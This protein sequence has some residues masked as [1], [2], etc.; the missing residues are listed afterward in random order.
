VPDHLSTFAATQR[1]NKKAT[2]NRNRNLAAYPG[3]ASDLTV[4]LL[5]RAPH[6]A[7]VEET[8]FSAEGLL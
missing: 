4:G 2:A 5:P 6:P 3:E 7:P 1:A 8:D